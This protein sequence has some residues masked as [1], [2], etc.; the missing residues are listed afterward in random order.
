M[1]NHFYDEN[2]AYT[3]HKKFDLLKWETLIAL[4]KW[5]LISLIKTLNIDFSK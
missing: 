4:M 5:L 1:V 2:C 3:Y